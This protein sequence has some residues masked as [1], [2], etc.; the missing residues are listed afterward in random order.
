MNRIQIA[1][2]LP[3]GQHTYTF[4]VNIDETKCTGCGICA[5]ECPSRIIDMTPHRFSN[6]ATLCSKN[7]LAENDVRAAMF[8][9]GNGG[10][11][12]DAW[13]SIT[14]V[15]PFPAC[16]GRACPHPCEDVCARGHLDESVNLHEFERF[17]GDYGIEHKLK[18]ETRA[19]K[20]PQ[21]VTIIG[22]G[23]AGLSCAYQLAKLGYGVTVYD[24]R[25]KPGGMLRYGGPAYRI[26]K[27]VLDAEIDSILSLGIDVRCGVKI[28]RDI[29]LNN[30]KTEYDAIYIAIG[31][32][33]CMKLGVP[34]DD[35]AI[36]SLDFLRS[37]VEG[38]IKNPGKKVVVIGGGNVAADCAR[39]ASRA[40]AG[41][42]T[43]VCVESRYDMPAYEEDIAESLEEGIEILPGWGVKSVS[44]G[45]IV[46]R[47][48]L[49]VFDGQGKFAP[50]YDDDETEVLAFDTL[51]SAIGQ[52]PDTRFLEKDGGVKTY[53]NGLVTIN[54]EE[55]GLTNV[56]DIYAGGD[57]TAHSRKGTLA[58]CVF[59]G[60]NAARTIAERLSC[61]G[62]AEISSSVPE[63][64][65]IDQQKYNTCIP[66][67]DT[68]VREARARIA[69]LRSEVVPTMEKQLLYKEIERCLVC[70]TAIAEYTGKQNAKKFNWACH[71]CHNC[72][73]VCPENAIN[74]EYATV[75][76]ESKF[77]FSD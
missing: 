64:D 71:N 56:L 7:C 6:C 66:R 40:G 12:E 25:E 65:E 16:I 57:V 75:D 34:R 55:D 51:I 11:L 46:L 41:H 70:A 45:K 5:I 32:Q 39:T 33:K 49:S 43:M 59:M 31:A 17:V 42:V 67:N 28:G 18:H 76:R 20:K 22:S 9:V 74:F 73:S 63:V 4:K 14:A 23:P 1:N 15:N 58:G 26:P 24:E 61:Q 10:S 35:L 68:P 29:L 77:V 48:C 60:N 2:M 13:K 38:T 54:D 72:V 36:P 3:V 52:E 21:K 37:A 8:R 53:A 62:Q 44:A 27:D 30:L 47:K 50:V 19:E 69:D